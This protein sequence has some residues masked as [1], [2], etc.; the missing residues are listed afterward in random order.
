VHAALAELALAEHYEAADVERALERAARET[1][2]DAGVHLEG[3]A[4]AL[5]RRARPMVARGLE[6]AAAYPGP[7][8]AEA[9]GATPEGLR[10]RADLLAHAAEGGVRIDFKTGRP[11][12]ERVRPK[13]RRAAL[14]AAVRRGTHLQAAA[15]A[16]APGASL[17]AYLHLDPELDL[18]VA[19]VEVQAGDEEFALALREAADVLADAW[20]SGS[21]PPRPEQADGK[22]NQACARCAV[23]PA[24]LRDDS[25]VRT[26]LRGLALGVG[27]G[28]SSDDLAVARLAGL[29]FLGGAVPDPE[30]PE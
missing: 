8:E 7:R 19:R 17:G 30:D 11:L 28:G 26:R 23:R 2:A 10:F 22:P 27:A 1:L 6:L 29:W 21:V 13:T 3:L 25:G 9:P 18:D 15:Y 16:A 14:L 24:C 20:R 4:L 5:A 12:S